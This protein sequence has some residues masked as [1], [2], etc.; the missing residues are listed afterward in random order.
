V[1][2]DFDGVEV[3]SAGV[4]LY[5]SM[6]SSVGPSLGQDHGSA[7]STRYHSPFAYTGD[8]LQVT[9]DAGRKTGAEL[10][11]EARSEMGRQ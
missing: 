1:H 10:A 8:L 11:A 2:L 3:A 4:S 5:M 7:V 9:I 6:M